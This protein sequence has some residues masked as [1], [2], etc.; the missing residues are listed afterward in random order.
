MSVINLRF[1]QKETGADEVLACKKRMYGSG[2]P[3]PEENKRF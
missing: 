1:F 3:F 2:F